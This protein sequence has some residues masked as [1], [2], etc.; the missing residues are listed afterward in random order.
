MNNNLNNNYNLISHRLEKINNMLMNANH[1]DP[2]LDSKYELTVINNFTSKLDIRD[3]LPK[4]YIDFSIAINNLGGKLLYIKSG[5]TGHTFKGVFPQSN[6]EKNTP[7]AVKIVAYP[8]KVNYGDIYNVK[9]PENTELLMIKLLSYFV[10]N[11][12][13]PHIILPITTFNTSI[14]PFLNLTKNNIINNKRFEQFIERYENGEYYQNVSV[15]VSEW[16][17]NGDLLD[18]LKKNYKQLTLLDWTVIFFQIISVLAIIQNKYPTFRHNDMKANNILI[19]KIDIDQNNKNYL[20]KINNKSFI[21]PN[22]GLQIKLWDFDFACIPNIVNNSK[23]EAE[24]T[25]KINIKPEM[26]KYYD[27]HYFFSTLTKKGFFPELLTNKETPNEILEFINRVI[28]NKYR[29]G[30]YV[31]ERGRL[32]D[33]NEYTTPDKLL[34]DVLFSYMKTS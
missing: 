5:S 19:H 12:N 8:K 1:I 15:L 16:A 29:S 22:I 24:W 20:Y 32:L 14:K 11:N 33:N 3:V 23:V 21:I 27:I 2:I 31:S 10:I 25:N 17:N 34:N 28:P 4:K 9:R 13:T 30:K 7:Y 18:F 6:N 26:N